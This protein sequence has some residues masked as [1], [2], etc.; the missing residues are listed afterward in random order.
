MIYH[1]AIK[2]YEEALKLATCGEPISFDGVHKSVYEYY[3]L[4]IEKGCEV[5]LFP[6]GDWVGKFCYCDWNDIM[7]MVYRGAILGWHTWKHKD[8]KNNIGEF[9]IVED[10]WCPY[11]TEHFALPYGRFNDKYLYWLNNKKDD[12]YFKYIY[13][14]NLEG[15]NIILRKEL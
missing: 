6:V 8:P 10:I 11:Q 12:Y 4:F 13:G 15:N 3:Y 14:T 2:N 5:Y 1:H 7:D 9:D